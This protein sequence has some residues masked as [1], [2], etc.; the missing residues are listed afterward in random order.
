MTA[1]VAVKVA[2]SHG[3]R[4][5]ADGSVLEAAGG[6]GM[7]ES[8]DLGFVETFG[9]AGQLSFPGGVGIEGVGGDWGV[10]GGGGGVGRLVA[11]A[12]QTGEQAGEAQGGDLK[13]IAFGARSR[14]EGHELGSKV[15]HG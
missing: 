9:K 4:Y 8:G 15:V 1:L 11:A 12:E 14:Q 13:E 3:H 10:G 7:M 6:R 2:R 5:V